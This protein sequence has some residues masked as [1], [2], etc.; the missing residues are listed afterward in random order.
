MRQTI[1]AKIIANQLTI[2]CRA[3][4]DIPTAF[5]FDNHR[6]ILQRR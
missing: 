1:E 2:N 6:Y 4:F 5:D 3:D